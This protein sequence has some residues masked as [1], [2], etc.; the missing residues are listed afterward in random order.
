MHKSQLPAAISVLVL[1]DSPTGPLPTA[2]H[3]VLACC[4]ALPGENYTLAEENENYDH[5]EAAEKAYGEVMAQGNTV[6]SWDSSLP[7]ELGGGHVTQWPTPQGTALRVTLGEF[8]PGSPSSAALY[9][10][11]G[12]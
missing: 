7:G 5:Y 1:G 8:G 12:E 9:V 4:A 3:L 2:L 11:P 10:L 6:S